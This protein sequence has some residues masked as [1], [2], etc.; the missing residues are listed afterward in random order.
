LEKRNEPG[1]SN[2]SRARGSGML[3][4]AT[5]AYAIESANSAWKPQEIVT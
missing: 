5:N 2:S 4:P 1:P 3:I